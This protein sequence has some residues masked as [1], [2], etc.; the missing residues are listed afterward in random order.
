MSSNAQVLT[1]L[2]TAEGQQIEL[3]GLPDLP[4][5]K[6]VRLAL[7]GHGWVTR[8]AAEKAVERLADVFLLTMVRT[9]VGVESWARRGAGEYFSSY[10]SEVERASGQRVLND[11]VG[12]TVYESSPPPRFESFNMRATIGATAEYV[13][14]SFRSLATT[15]IELTDRERVAIDLFNASFFE[16]AADTRLLVLVMAIQPLIEPAQRPPDSVA[17]VNAFID[18]A[19]TSLPEP[20]RKSLS[21]AL[22]LLRHES[23]RDAGRRLAQQRLGEAVYAGQSASSFFDYCYTLRNRLVHGG[24]IRKAREASASVV[25]ELERFVSE[26]LT[27]RFVGTTGSD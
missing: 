11:S 22:Q 24:D 8:E 20:E 15:E 23:Y 17:L 13:V 5:S 25:M 12:P 19:R 21:N 2:E 4:I 18:K 3:V 7:Q 16:P 26:L 1:L 14:K 6:S 9:R 10:L 27:W